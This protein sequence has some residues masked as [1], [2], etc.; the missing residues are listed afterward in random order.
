MKYRIF[1]AFLLLPLLLPAQT[2]KEW[3]QRAEKGDVE[4]MHRMGNFYFNGDSVPQNY[5]IA[6]QWYQKSAKFNYPN[7][8]HN[9]AIYYFTGR[10]LPADTLKALQLWHQAAAQNFTASMGA[11]AM[12]YR[13]GGTYVNPD[14][15]FYWEYKAAELGDVYSQCLLSLYYE[16][17]FGV[18]QN[19][20]ESFKWLLRA[21][22]AG[23]D[24]AAEGVAKNYRDG[25]GVEQDFEKMIQWFEIAAAR[26][27]NN[28]LVYLGTLYQQGMY[29]LPI[30]KQKAFDMFQRAA[31]QGD[32]WGEF[33]LGEC[34]RFGRGTTQDKE[35]ARYWIAK[36]AEQGWQSAIIAWNEIDTGIDENELR[37]KNEEYKNW[38]N[39]NR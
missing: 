6:L 24:I 39:A 19:N 12:V 23:D 4:A 16:R 13:N 38:F 31:M 17:G 35:L 10:E 26:G 30:D 27:R 9:I 8:L 2:F 14:S 29:G 18:E 33:E 20:E 1:I 28:S 34:Y 5:K 25:V 15:C 22:E 21:A 11:I 32:A 3:K 36:S 7:S 37:R